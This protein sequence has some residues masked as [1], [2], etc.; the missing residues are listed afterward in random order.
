MNSPGETPS[1]V[2]V[3][4]QTAPWLSV[5]I[6]VYNVSAWVKDCLHSVLDQGDGA[7]AV[8]IVVL[9]D[10]S[11]DGSWAVVEQV[12][13]DH[14]QRMRVLRHA[15]NRGVAAARNTL[16]AQARGRYVWFLDSDD[17]LL[18]GAI[19]GLRAQVEADWPD[20]LLC[21]FQELRD[22]SRWRHCVRGERHRRSFEGGDGRTTTD[23]LELICGLLQSR[24]LH[25]WSKIAKREIW[26]R[27]RFPEGRCFEDVATIP[28]LVDGV[29]SWRHVP[30]PWVG[31]RKR[32]DSIVATKTPDNV[33][34]MLW[35]LRSLRDGL[36][37]LPHG[38]NARAWTTLD[39]FCLRALANLA[40]SVP[41]NDTQLDAECREVTADVLSQSP[42]QVLAACRRRGW[43]LR[44][45]RAQRS[46]ARRGWLR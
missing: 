46:L 25:P 8:E 15:S 28:A 33:R 21:D 27:V 43:W 34:D 37:G 11:S 12:A 23:R 20:L 30:S 13:R 26:T 10:V 29:S 22:R 7:G 41:R 5:L 35:A 9:D 4:A 3:D 19:A 6:P 32:G 42:R 40:R 18:P 45:W 17:V 39:Y 36:A 1:P 16:L 31:Y 2:S 14:P 24:Q 38:L 44:A